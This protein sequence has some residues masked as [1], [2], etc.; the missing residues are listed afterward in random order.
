MI[1]KRA[2][3]A[4]KVARLGVQFRVSVLGSTIIRLS[5]L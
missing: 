3:R 1:S 4:S 5:C 2:L